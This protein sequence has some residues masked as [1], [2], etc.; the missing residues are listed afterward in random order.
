MTLAS[1]EAAYSLHN[2]NVTIL[3]PSLKQKFLVDFVNGIDVSR[4][5]IKVQDLRGKLPDRLWDALTGDSYQRQV[6]INNQIVSGLDSCLEWLSDLTEELTLT[7]MAVMQVSEGLARVKSNLSEVANFSVDTR[8]QLEQ[9]KQAV[10]TRLS[11][12]QEQLQQVDMNARARAQMDLL[13]SS[14]RAGRFNEL[15]PAQRCFLVLTELA[16]GAFSDYCRIATPSDKNN[17]L[18]ELQNRLIEILARDINVGP[19]CYIDANAWFAQIQSNMCVQHEALCYLGNQINPSQQS[20]NQYA[21]NPSSDRPIKV[22]YIMT[23]SRLV[24]GMMQER[25]KEGVLY[26]A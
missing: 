19:S 9:F 21:L 15:S 25:I 17:I 12:L 8:E 14:W 23:A 11:A 22:P 10:D 4:D 16:W 26:V 13:F 6:E 7:N 5:R 3:M 2:D 24:N 20:F 1:D 18:L